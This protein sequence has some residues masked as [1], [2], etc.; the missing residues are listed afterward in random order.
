MT[1]DPK[2]L[3]A[4]A[5]AYDKEDAAQ[6]GEADP[7]KSELWD[8]GHEENYPEWVAERIACAEAGAAAFL[9]ASREPAPV[10][11]QQSTPDV[12]KGSE[13]IFIIAV[14]RARNGKVYTY[15]ASYLNA[16][17]LR[18]EY[19][20]PKGD[21]CD[22][23]GCD[24]GCP[25][26]GW[27]DA[28]GDGDDGLTY[29]PIYFEKGD[30][31]LG[32]REIPAWSAATVP[33]VVG[34]DGQLGRFGHHPDPAIDFE[35]EVGDIEAELI[36]IKGGFENGTPTLD[37]IRRRIDKAMDFRVG[38]VETCV[39]AK[40]RLRE[41]EKEAAALAS[42]VAKPCGVKADI[43]A[44]AWNCDQ[45]PDWLHDI[46][47][48]TNEVA[49]RL[50][51]SAEQAHAYAALSCLSHPAQGWREHSL[52]ARFNRLHSICSRILW[53]DASTPALEN[54]QTKKAFDE[55]AEYLFAAGID[56]AIAAAP[57]APAGGSGNE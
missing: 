20:C 3:M 43:E 38:A 25:T 23:E 19:E 39:S 47:A 45:W 8:P 31:F 49:D 14:Q 21:G 17:P 50:D 40:H 2:A 37:E 9:G 24:D 53:I 13:R 48:K 7:W 56:E 52:A 44:Q 16:Y 55:L 33:P 12:P 51:M 41:L 46:V 35:V 5:H 57:S 4:L 30:E 11:W 32:W 42:S 15:P 18:F 28:T 54:A 34:E 29:T 27:Y 36:N 1:L 26:T 22:G 6:R 10:A